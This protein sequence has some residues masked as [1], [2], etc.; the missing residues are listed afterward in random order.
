MLTSVTIYYLEMTAREQLQP[1]RSPRADLEFLRVEPPNPDTNRI[2]Y[3]DVGRL[4]HWTDRLPWTPEQ[5]RAYV[6]RPELE[7]WIARVNGVAAGYAELE[8]QDHRN[9]EI[10]Y[11][12]LLPAFVGQGHGGHFLTETIERAWALGADRVWVHTCTL[13]HPA[14][15]A[16]YLARGFR[17]YREETHSKAAPNA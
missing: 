5:W 4:W 13:D 10:A 3:R 15:L 8:L 17:Q 12:G 14:A 2:Y 9:V 1:Q 16:N 6:E 7:T 11:F